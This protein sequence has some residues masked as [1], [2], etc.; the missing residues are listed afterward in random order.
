MTI[1]LVVGGLPLK[2]QAFNNKVYLSP[3]TYSQTF[4]PMS[5]VIPLLRVGSYVYLAEAHHSV[6][7]GQIG[8]NSLQ[9]KA[10]RLQMEE[11]TVVTCVDGGP[12]TTLA[13]ITFSVDLLVKKK[14][15]DGKPS[16]NLKQVD[17]D[18]LLDS[19]RSIHEMQVFKIGQNIA[20]DFEGTKYSLAVV[21]MSHVSI[22]EE[23]GAECEFGQ[24]LPPTSI[25]FSKAGGAQLD[26]SGKS[27][28]SAGG[29]AANR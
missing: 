15:A 4:A 28:T 13:N 6:L 21:G 23:G 29:S 17:C 12:E 16:R 7:D 19:F 24:V 25:G 9:R 10:C 22:G 8:M 1:S 20:V 27:L 2:N 5:T 14:S 18:D 11:P 3:N 26:L